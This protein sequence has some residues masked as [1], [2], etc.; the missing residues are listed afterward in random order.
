MG[1]DSDLLEDYEL[2]SDVRW[3]FFFFP[4][5]SSERFSRTPGGLIL[6]VSL[7]VRIS[8]WFIVVSPRYL[9]S[10]SSV[11]PKP[12]YAVS[13]PPA[14]WGTLQNCPCFLDTYTLPSE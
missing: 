14:T 4:P 12:R 1:G 3:V 13:S 10:D 2:D 6:G 7:L 9:P 11:S 8:I 5:P